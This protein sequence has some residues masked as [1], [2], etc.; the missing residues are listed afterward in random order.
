MSVGVYEELVA[1]P[2]DLLILDVSDPSE[3]VALLKRVRASS[4]LKRIAVLVIAE[5]GTGQSTLALSNGADAIERK[6][7]DAPRLSA[8]V[9]RLLQPHMVLTARAGT[10][11][12]ED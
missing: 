8:A 2:P 5:W 3:G 4:S 6:P 11:G 12:D 9:T 10:N 1:S 7:I